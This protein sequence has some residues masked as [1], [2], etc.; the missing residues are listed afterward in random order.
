M[1]YTVLLMAIAA[2]LSLSGQSALNRSVLSIE[3]I[4]QGEK[5]VG[6]SPEAVRW[7]DDGTHILF[8]WN[9][10]Q[11]TIRRLYAL[12]AASADAKARRATEAELLQGEY[13]RASYDQGYTRR[14]YTL[15]GDLYLQN[16]ADGQ[17]RRLCQTIEAEEEPIFSADGQ[18]IIYRR[19]DNLFTLDLGNGFT[20]QMTNISKDNE[21]ASGAGS[22]PPFKTWLQE[23]QMELVGVLRDRAARNTARQHQREMLRPKPMQAIYYGNQRLDY[24]SPSPNL[25]YVAYRLSSPPPN[26]RTQVPDYVTTSGFT[27]MLRARPKVGSPEDSYALHIYDRQRDTVYE[28]RLNDLPGIHDKPAFLAEYHR[29]DS[30]YSARYDQPKPT[31]IHGPFWSP[32]GAEAVVEVRSLDS[33]DRWIARIIPGEGSLQVID[34]QHDDAWIGGPGI[35]GWLSVPGTIGWLPDSKRIYFQSEESGY[36]H[37]YVADLSGGPKRALTSG[38]WEVL[39]VSLNQAGDVFYL[40]ANAEGPHEQH[41]YHLPVDGGRL[42]RITT[43]KGA[44]EV[45]VSPDENWLAVRYS[46]SNQPWELY[47]QE[48]KPGAQPRQLT[49]STTAAFESYAWRTPELVYFTARDGA[50]VPARLYRP[51]NARRGGPAVIFVHGAGYLQN[52]HHWWSTYFREYMFHNLLADNGYT[53]LDIDYRASAGYGRDWRTAIYRHMGG[54]DLTDHVDGARYLSQSLGVDPK[55]IGIY[56]GSYGGFITLMALFKEPQVFACGA[57]LRSVTDWAHYNHP[58]TANILNTPV[59][60]SVA[61]QRSSPIYFAEGLQKP[62]LMLHGMVDTNV[63]FQDV[64]RLSQRLIELGKN[65]WEMAIFPMEDHGFVE[66]SSWSDEYKRIFRLFQTHLKE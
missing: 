44:H 59:L 49:H 3:G 52:V 42:T 12:E 10:E 53:V 45:V 25:Q 36:S 51:R 63:Q 28:V 26:H 31:I 62:L 54:K 46:A 41:F 20:E 14:V 56:G 60:D 17:T 61:Y 7:S 29:N 16:L 11:D 47:V 58:Y 33:K 13:S 50:Q 6:Y 22:N 23:D 2:N 48:N 1:R 35:E 27:E 34:W 8:S 32:D 37:L 19:G 39:E 18:K 24:L 30:S 43:A 15:F 65:Q 55:R 21:Q 57:A 64:V 66:P 38:K 40:T 9:P 4:M 5:F